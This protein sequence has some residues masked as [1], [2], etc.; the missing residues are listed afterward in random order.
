MQAYFACNGYLGIG[1]QLV[2]LCVKFAVMHGGNIVTYSS[3]RS[4]FAAT[5]HIRLRDHVAVWLQS[6][7][8]RCASAHNVLRSR[9]VLL[10]VVTL[11]VHRSEVQ[12]SDTDACSALQGWWWRV[13]SGD[14]R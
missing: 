8:N 12:Y 2:K 14:S 11:C 1:K 4:Y 5:S 7:G 13:C 9:C 10:N 6:Q 3:S